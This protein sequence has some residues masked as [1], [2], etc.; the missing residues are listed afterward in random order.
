ML[1]LKRFALM[2]GETLGNIVIMLNEVFLKLRPLVLIYAIIIIVFH[3]LFRYLHDDD[4]S[5]LLDS[6]GALS[7]PNL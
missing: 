4:Q 1:R 7:L 5:Q 6:F 3:Q 2:F